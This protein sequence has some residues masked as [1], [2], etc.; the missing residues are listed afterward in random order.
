MR[1][2]ENCI[3]PEERAL[4]NIKDTIVSKCEFKGQIEGESA[5]KESSNVII[6]D[7]YFDLRY[8]LWHVDT[9]SITSSTMTSN[10]R[11]PLWYS[12]NVLIK[13]C[14]IGGVKAVRECN[15]IE[16]TCSNIESNEF[17]WKNESVKIIQSNIIGEYLFFDTKDI[18][19]DKTNLLGKYSLQYISNSIIENSNFDTK[20]MLWHAKNVTVRNCNIKGEYLGWYCED[21]TFID[22]HISGTQP[23]CYAKN[24][25]LINCTMDNCDLSFEYSSVDATINGNVTSIKNPISGKIEVDS[26]DEIITKDNKYNTLAKV[27]VRNKETL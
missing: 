8:P 25:K 7:C 12:N 14:Y 9:A 26:C 21:V 18:Y 17:G 19:M 3:F 22:C 20:D 10:C 5:L 1:K 4:Y 24:L 27:V 13:E 2:I 6:E 11:A 16:I 23:L 15:N